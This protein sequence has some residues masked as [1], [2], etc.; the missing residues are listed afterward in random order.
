MEVQSVLIP[1]DKYSKKE[2]NKW[3]KNNGYI[4][5]KIDITNN[6]YRYR[7]MEPELL[8]KDSYR[9]KTLNNGIILIL[10]KKIKHSAYKSMLLGKLGLTKS[11]PEK[12]AN[13]RR[14]IL[15]KW[16]NL[17]PIILN[18][19]KFYKCGKKSKEQ[20]KLNLPSV[21]RPS[22]KISDETPTPLSKDLTKKQ[23]KKAVKIKQK[24]EYIKW[25]Y[26]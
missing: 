15:E 5:K 11:T 26:L 10:G 19:D 24:E 7:Q 18:D 13:L 9:T 8:I 1:K 25:N 22:V 14:W 2:A 20:I 16:Q 17:T 12:K 21:C 6:Y 23:I 3:I 4:I